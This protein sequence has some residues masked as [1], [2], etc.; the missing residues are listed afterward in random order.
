[1]EITDL[2]LK[3]LIHG[4][5]NLTHFLNQTLWDQIRCLHDHIS[6]MKTNQISFKEMNP[7]DS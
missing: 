1:M 4:Q 7:F 3:A 2:C 6:L 5:I